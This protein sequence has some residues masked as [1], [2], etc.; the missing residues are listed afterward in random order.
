MPTDGMTASLPTPYRAEMP[1]VR[2]PG[3]LG[4]PSALWARGLAVR[5]PLP[6]RPPGAGTQP[7]MSSPPGHAAP[8]V[9]SCSHCPPSCQAPCPLRP[10]REL[11]AGHTCTA[12]V[13]ARQRRAWRHGRPPA[14]G[15]P[16]KANVAGPC[17][18]WA[19]FAGCRRGP[20]SPGKDRAPRD[21][22]SPGADRVCVFQTRGRPFPAGGFVPARPLRTNRVERAK[23]T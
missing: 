15:Q 22:Q 3:G 1:L 4:Q 7:V 19:T 13:G 6:A 16:K 10:V 18:P 14:P 9:L 20:A 11:M 5:T 17:E 8:A 12:A 2:P 23:G 21:S